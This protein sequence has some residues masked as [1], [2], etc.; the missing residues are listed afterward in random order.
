M[1]ETFTTSMKTEPG[2]MTPVADSA[3]IK[4]DAEAVARAN[5]TSRVEDRMSRD[6][7]FAHETIILAERVPDARGLE[8]IKDP[9]LKAKVADALDVGRDPVSMRQLGRILA[10]RYPQAADKVLKQAKFLERA[11]SAR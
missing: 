5:P 1:S 11:A 8:E 3:P 10:I 4:I 2:R 9:F 6:R 7:A